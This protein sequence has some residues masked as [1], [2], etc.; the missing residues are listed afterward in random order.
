MND[1][2]NQELPLGLY[3]KGKRTTVD[4]IVLPFQSLEVVETINESRATREKEKGTMFRQDPNAIDVEWRNKLIWGDNKYVMSALLEKYAGKIDLIYIDPPFATGANFETTVRIGEK[5]LKHT[6]EP[7]A[8]EE[9]AYRDTWGKGLDSFLQ[10]MYDRIVLIRELLSDNG[11]L[12]IHLDWRTTHYVKLILD[13][14][15]G[16]NYFMNSIVWCYKSGGAG[17][18]GFSKKHDYILAYSKSDKKTFNVLQE[19]SYMKPG[20][21]KNPAQTYYEDENG[22]YTLVNIK[23]WWAD[24]GMLATS[25]Y[26][27]VDYPTQ[28][29]EALIERIVKASTNENDLVADFFCGSGTTAAVAEKLGRK[30]IV[31]DIGRYAIH[32]TRKRMLEIDGCQPFEI[33]N[34]GKYERQYWQSFNFGKKTPEQT[35]AEYIG[36]VLKLYKAEALPGSAFIHGKKGNKLVHIGGVDAPVTFGDIQHALEDTRRM[37]QKELVVLGWE[38]EM[39]LHDVVEQEAEKAGIKLQLLSIPREAMDKRAVDAGDIQFFEL[40]YLESE[41][42]KSAHGYQIKLTDF[43]IPNLDLIPAEVKKLIKKWSDYIDYWSVDWDYK[44]DTFHNQWQSYRTKKDRS[45]EL[46][47]D[48][49][50]YDKKGDYKVMVKVIDIFGNDT[51]HIIEL[52]HR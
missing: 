49:K 42:K 19:K 1:N 16:T 9:V 6:K 14:V 36:F 35:L 30:W 28:K 46:T 23:D 41:V 32:T 40:A 29:P 51:T 24:I 39:G 47:S 34:I 31:A 44:D 21:G 2:N 45:L 20:S 15:F 10:M 38:W 12:Y 48:P 37:K 27:R 4:R 52:K 17:D 26:E 11:T 13:E 50:Q 25:S 7:S 43:V 3:W 5:D 8:I 22:S 33:L 18:N